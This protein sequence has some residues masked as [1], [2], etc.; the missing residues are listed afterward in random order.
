[1]SHPEQQ[2]ILL[3]DDDAAITEGLSYTLEAEGRRIIVCSDVEAAELALSHFPVTHLVT[4]LQFSGDFGFEGLHFLS[5]VRTAASQCRVVLMSGQVTEPLRKAALANGAAAVL[6]KPFTTEELEAILGKPEAT[7]PFEM[8]RIPF[9][10]EILTSDE[11]VAAFQPIVRL[12]PE[13]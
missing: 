7:T 9:I 12:T 1:M 2:C 4:D 8:L 10:E 3:V 13:G 5:R 11:I 6:S